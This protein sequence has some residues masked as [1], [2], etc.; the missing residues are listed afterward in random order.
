MLEKFATL[1]EVGIS[2]KKNEGQTSNPVLHFSRLIKIT[3]VWL[4]SPMHKS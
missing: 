3:K 4:L 1:L 2:E